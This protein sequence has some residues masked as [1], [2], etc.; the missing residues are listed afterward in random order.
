MVQLVNIMLEVSEELKVRFWGVRG[1]TTP[2]A[3]G[4]GGFLV[5]LIQG[6]DC[7]LY[8]L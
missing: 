2:A 6:C 1:P 5:A 4:D 8:I 7:V 3:S